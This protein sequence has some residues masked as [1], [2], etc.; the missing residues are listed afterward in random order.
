MG[1]NTDLLLRV[2][3]KRELQL[4]F[5]SLP[6]RPEKGQKRE[7]R[8]PYYEKLAL[9][10]CAAAVRGVGTYGHFLPGHLSGIYQYEQNTQRPYDCKNEPGRLLEYGE[11]GCGSRRQGVQCEADVQGAGFG[12]RH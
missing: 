5:A 6:S 2:R 11:A 4:P 3:L 7:G 1:G 10:A 9:K 12:K 8:N